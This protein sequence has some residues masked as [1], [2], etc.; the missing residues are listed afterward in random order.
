MGGVNIV[1]RFSVDGWVSQGKFSQAVQDSGRDRAEVTRCVGALFADVLQFLS[2]FPEYSKLQ[3]SFRGPDHFHIQKWEF[4]V[5]HDL[6][7]IFLLGGR[8][9][10]F[11][12]P[13]FC[14]ELKVSFSRRRVHRLLKLFQSV[15]YLT[16]FLLTLEYH[17]AVILIDSVVDC[18]AEFSLD[19]SKR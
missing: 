17:Q 19:F 5:H 8:G 1:Y 6:N 7:S 18:R 10:R 3:V 4:V 11:V 2:L 9:I 14:G 16:R 12:C 13:Y 15:F